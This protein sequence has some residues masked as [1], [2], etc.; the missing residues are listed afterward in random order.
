MVTFGTSLLVVDVLNGALAPSP[1]W[2]RGERILYR[3]MRH[4]P[5]I[6]S[7][8]RR[9]VLTDKKVIIE[10]RQAG[11]DLKGDH[12]SDILGFGACLATLYFSYS[13]FSP[14]SLQFIGGEIGPAE[15]L[16]AEYERGFLVN[17]L[18]SIT[19]SYAEQDRVSQQG[20]QRRET[21]NTVR[22]VGSHF[23]KD[24]PTFT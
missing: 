23:N 7:L 13:I 4:P 11:E 1:S 3:Q 2:K 20:R 18:T 16:P 5:N 24:T 14:V 19:A 6:Y 8:K 9:R 15:R 10:F 17:G 12:E 21:K 22:G